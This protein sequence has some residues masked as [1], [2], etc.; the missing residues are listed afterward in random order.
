MNKLIRAASGC[1]LAMA[2]SIAMGA[3]PERP[4]RVIVPFPPGGSTDVVARLLGERMSDS[5]K[6][7]VVIDNR[8]GA[9][10]NLG[11][12]LAARS[13]PDGYTIVMSTVAT[14]TINQHLYGKL[15]FDP[16]RDFV[17][18]NAV[19]SA[20]QVLLT[21]P[22]AGIASVAELIRMA[23]AKPNAIIAGSASVGTTGHLS[24]ELLKSVTGV[25]ITH[26]PYKGAGPAQIAL[27][28]GETQLLFDSITTAVPHIKS[29]RARALGVTSGKRSNVLP[30][31]PAI[32][33][34]IP[35]FETIGW[36]ALMAPAGTPKDVQAKLVGVVSNAL[37]EKEV[38]AKV[39]GL[40][41]EVMT[42]SG[43]PLAQYIR[44][45]REKWGKVIRQAGI[46]A[47]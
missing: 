6:Q 29:G 24:L 22:N 35:G 27:I 20:F 3:F 18:L 25:Q 44:A 36:F 9:S 8:P 2:A 43:D 30:E 46:R 19:A 37:G 16:E 5:L 10:G 42:L 14:L 15:R 38:R 33:E 1:A 17:P 39:E 47:E 34:T 26:V 21:N 32:A 23:K 40:G 31:V 45:E 41:A 7:V 11:T 4:V 13:A 12:E 28:S